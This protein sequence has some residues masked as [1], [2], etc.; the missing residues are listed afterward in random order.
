MIECKNITKIYGVGNTQTKAL[1][2]ISLK[3]DTGEFVAIMGSSGSGKSTLMHILGLL[4]S[5]TSGEYFFSSQDVSKLSENE[6]AE[7]RL[8]KIGFVFQAFNL[9]ARATIVR[10]IQLP[11]LYSGLPKNQRTEKMK[12]ALQ[13]VGLEDQELWFHAS[14]Q[15]S[16]GQIQRVAIARALVNDPNIIFAD[17]PTGNLD[18]KTSEVVMGT[19][20]QLN[21]KYQRTIIVITHEI[22]VAQFAD[23]IIILRDG[24]IAMDK[25]NSNKRTVKQG[26]TL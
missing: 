21:K 23:R 1:D 26:L 25:R 20:E 15:L 17:E 18:S 8:K 4:D 19:F 9:L 5:P 2:G 24:M 10:N 16:G 11:F 13:A 6:L 22:E 7:I 14:N 12:H 3:V